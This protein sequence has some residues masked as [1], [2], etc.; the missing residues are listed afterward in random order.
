[1]R[2]GISGAQ[3]CDCKNNESPPQGAETKKKKKEK[4]LETKSEKKKARD[5]IRTF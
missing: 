1:M 5:L 3:E 4:K 2:K